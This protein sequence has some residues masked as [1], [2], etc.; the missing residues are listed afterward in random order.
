MLCK[1][2]IESFVVEFDYFV[3]V[4]YLSIYIYLEIP[5]G[6]TKFIVISSR[7]SLDSIFFRTCFK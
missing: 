2:I 7:F 4:R 3:N 1:V 5:T 6:I